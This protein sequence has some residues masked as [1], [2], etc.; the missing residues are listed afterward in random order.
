M[1]R[2]SVGQPP[3]PLAAT[4]GRR[5]STWVGIVAVTLAFWLGALSMSFAG[6]I[7]G[8]NFAAGEPQTGWSLTAWAAA[9]LLAGTPVVLAKPM[10]APW[11]WP[12]TLVAAVATTIVWFGVG[13]LINF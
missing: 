11:R 7:L 13:V 5:R 9:A 12:V 10:G 3:D 8:S 6:V 4:P 2:S 1:P